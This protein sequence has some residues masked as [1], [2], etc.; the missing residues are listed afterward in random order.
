MDVIFCLYEKYEKLLIL[1]DIG[2]VHSDLNVA[3]Y[4]HLIQQLVSA[5]VNCDV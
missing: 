5:H 3:F 2:K 1:H 4:M